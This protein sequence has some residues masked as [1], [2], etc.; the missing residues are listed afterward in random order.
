M[1]IHPSD[2]HS[3]SWGGGTLGGAA[4]YQ[5]VPLGTDAYWL[6]DL[7]YGTSET[8]LTGDFK[9]QFVWKQPVKH[10]AIS[11]HQ[12]TEGQTHAC[13]AYKAWT[14]STPA[15]SLLDRFTTAYR[16]KVTSGGPIAQSSVSSLPMVDKD[17][18]FGDA[19]GDLYFNFYYS[20]NGARI[21]LDSQY[22]MQCEGCNNDATQGL[23]MDYCTYSGNSRKS[24]QQSGCRWGFDVAER[25][26]PSGRAPSAGTDKGDSVSAGTFIGQ[27]AIW[28][29]SGDLPPP[30]V[31]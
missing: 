16:T 17:P 30:F 2:G 26:S 22:E 11:R 29:F 10:I 14:F 20:N 27:F 5:N 31:C 23:G 4:T 13:E 12:S 15:L 28:V 21:A 25:K 24:G 18:I 6:Q 9:S 8:A 19:D 1:N 3:S 7:Q